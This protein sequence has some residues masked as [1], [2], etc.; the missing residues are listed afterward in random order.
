MPEDACPPNARAADTSLAPPLDPAGAVAVAEGRARLVLPPGTCAAIAAGH[1]RMQ[2]CIAQERLVYGIT[3]GFGPLADRIVP[4]GDIET[5]QRNLIAHLATGVGADLGWREARLV[6]LAR[7]L[8]LARG[9]SGASPGLVT[10]LARL[11]ASPFA[12]RIPEKGT[13]GASGDLTPL[14]HLALALMGEGAFMDRAGRPVAPADAEAALGGWHGLDGRDG[15]ALVNGTSAMTGIAA[16]NTVEAARLIAWAEALTVGFAELLG[17]RRE[18]WDPLLAELRGQPGQVASTAA[19][20]CR[21]EG[22]TRLT[23]GRAADRLLAEDRPTGPILQDAYTIRCAPQILGTIRDQ[24]AWAN[25]VV[26]RE[27]AGAT[28][29]PV[30]PEGSAPALHGGN[31]MGQPVAAASDMLAMAV[32]AL[33]GLVERQIARLTDER[34]NGGL[35]AFLHRG[36]A[37]LNSGLMGAQVTATALLA[38]MRTRA[39]PASI[40][41]ISTNGANQDVVSMGTI[42]AR[43]ARCQIADC[44]HVLAVLALAVAQGAEI[45]PGGFAPATERLVARVRAISPPLERDRPLSGEIRALAAEI[46]A[47]E[48]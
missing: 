32:V 44:A 29:N 2:T 7:L 12:P 39:V 21:A 9:V 22:S 31:F 15:L 11:I 18:A 10:R 34:L 6:A 25:G 5:L 41:S 45:A 27:L 36:P 46:L 14:A 30:F 24:A 43:T 3:T 47:C 35:P 1:A 19:L 13:V 20:A 17:G 28:D 42:A 48:A 33:A 37:G 23:P 26:A 16:L 40:Q 38:E 4:A 8:S